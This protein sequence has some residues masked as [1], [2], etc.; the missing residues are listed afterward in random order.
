MASLAHRTMRIASAGV[1]S[2]L[3]AAP[4]PALAAADDDG[5]RGRAVRSHRGD[6]DPGHRD[7]GRS[8]ARRGG[9]RREVAAPARAHL[10]RGD[11]RD[12]D[13]DRH[14]RFERRDRHEHHD[15]GHRRDRGEHRERGERRHG[16]RPYGTP[17]RHEGRNERRSW[18]AHPHHERKD[19]RHDRKHHDARKHHDRHDW[20]PVPWNHARYVVHHDRHWHWHGDRWC[21]PGHRHP[22]GRRV[23]WHRP[24]HDDW[25]WARY[26]RPVIVYGSYYCA[27][28][29]GWYH[30]RHAFDRHVFSYHGLARHAFADAVAEMVWGL[31]YFG[32]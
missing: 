13:R 30:D 27:P 29:A 10:E 22:P 1:L 24:Q 19:P 2:L 31:V 23:G 15:R 28:C 26:R 14:D 12:R 5:R 32:L 11:R 6:R 18:H 4:P 16:D 17:D 9:G 20:R 7:R 25:R 3:L 21:P 8:E